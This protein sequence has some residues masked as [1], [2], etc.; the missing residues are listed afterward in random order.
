MFVVVGTVAPAVVGRVIRLAALETPATT[1]LHPS[2]VAVP[3]SV[4]PTWPDR[5][6]PFSDA[7]E[8]NRPSTCSMGRLP[9]D[10]LIA[11]LLNCSV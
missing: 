11:V 3:E 8:D 5:P 10:R 4:A 2:A 1:A 6:K 7:A 9:L